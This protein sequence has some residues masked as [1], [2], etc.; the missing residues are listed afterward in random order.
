MSLFLPKTAKAQVK[1]SVENPFM[2]PNESKVNNQ[3]KGNSSPKFKD[4]DDECQIPTELDN[5]NSHSPQCQSKIQSFLPGTNE[6]RKLPAV[7]GSAGI[8]KKSL[9]SCKMVKPSREMEEKSQTIIKES[10]KMRE[11]EKGNIDS[12][13][14]VALNKATAQTSITQQLKIGGISC[15]AEKIK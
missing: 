8:S 14:D 11:E 9:D 5:G 7:P 15:T 12:Q 10:P 4:E 6:V 13:I 3:E 1:S 2:N